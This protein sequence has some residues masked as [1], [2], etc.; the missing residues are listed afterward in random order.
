MNY[1]NLLSLKMLT[2]ALSENQTIVVVG[3]A[4]LL[5]LAILAALVIT[6]LFRGKRSLYASG[7]TDSSEMNVRIYRYN[8][9]N[10]TFYSFDRI[11]PSNTK[12]FTEKEF[13]AQFLPSDKY[14][15]QDWLKDIAHGDNN[16]PKFI[17][18]D[19]RI[20]KDNKMIPTMLE[21]TSIN[22]KSSLIHFDSHLF[23]SL[24]A[25]N[26]KRSPKKMKKYILINEEAAHEFLEHEDMEALGATFYFSLYQKDETGRVIANK[27][28]AD[29]NKKIVE[30]IGRFLTKTRKLLV[31]NPLDEVV[32]DTSV[33]S[34]ATAY[35]IA[36]T[37]ATSVQQYL[38]YS[39]PDDDIYFAIGF[40]VGS[41]YGHDYPKAKFQSSSMVKAIKE[42]YSKEK[43]LFYDS[44]FY[45]KYAR[46]QSQNQEIVM[47]VKNATF[48]I[49]YMPS[50]D[51]SRK[52]LAFYFTDI[53]PYGTEITDF[54]SVIR[55]ASEIKGGAEK[56]L[57]SV[58]ERCEADLADR[59]RCSIALRLPY[60]QVESFRHILKKHKKLDWIIEIREADL[61]TYADDMA[62]VNQELEKVKKAGIQIALVIDN[63]S[64]ELRKKTL[65]TFDYFFIPPK[66]TS[67]ML[68]FSTSH[69][70]LRIIETNYFGYNVPLVFFGLKDFDDIEL[71]A[72]YSGTIFQ[73]DQLA[74]PSSRF[75]SLEEEKVVYIDKVTKSLL[76]HHEET[77]TLSLAPMQVSE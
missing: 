60:A 20:S 4:I 33:A 32:I 47:V 68:D 56:L 37:I 59:P 77:I 1:Q 42:G 6:L 36:S 23:P 25:S 55:M 64:S 18:A 3:V 53:V 51:L 70:N 74:L 10:K 48:R 57:E 12:E 28:L 69:N 41:F 71:C 66:F 34:R 2:N 19:I 35:T 24:F 16:F 15:V 52:K 62:N 39:I 44:E 67:E 27:H 17:Q 40:S 9:A 45:A 22:H 7:A 61:T 13:L 65:K 72:H 50:L 11:D 75:E 54:Q 58:V 14:R 63:S 8:Y 30:V 5:S 46:R 38:N 21:F 29:V 49:Y 31:I 26:I 73:C 43:I 76:P